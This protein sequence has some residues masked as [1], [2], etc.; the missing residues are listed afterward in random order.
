MF[1]AAASSCSLTVITS[2]SL[3][4]IKLDLM[5]AIQ[6]SKGRRFTSSCQVT[7]CSL[8][9]VTFSVSPL[10]LPARVMYQHRSKKTCADPAL[11]PVSST[12]TTAITDWVAAWFPSKPPSLVAA[13]TAFATRAFG[14]GSECYHNPCTTRITYGASAAAQWFWMMKNEVRNAVWVL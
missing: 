4:G 8:C 1:S 6:P 14:L 10:L 9:S 5:H 2:H 12:W 3:M 13:Q 11:P 7:L